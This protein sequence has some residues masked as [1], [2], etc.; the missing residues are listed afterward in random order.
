VA[1]ISRH[2]FIPLWLQ[3]S[4]LFLMSEHDFNRPYRGLELMDTFVAIEK[5]D[6][7]RYGKI[8]RAFGLSNRE[9]LHRFNKFAKQ[10]NMKPPPG[11]EIPIMPGYLVVRRLGTPNQYETWIP[12]RVF[13]EIYQKQNDS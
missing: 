2:R 6:A 8:V 10:N 5:I 7:Q 12:D 13:E 4:T 3:L 1:P 9:Y 11:S